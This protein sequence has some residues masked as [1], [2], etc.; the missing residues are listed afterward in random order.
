MDF[1][2]NFFILKI[3]FMKILYAF[4]IYSLYRNFATPK[5]ELTAANNALPPTQN[6]IKLVSN[7]NSAIPASE[8]TCNAVNSIAE[9]STKNL[10][11]EDFLFLNTIL[12][13]ISTYSPYIIT[14]TL[15]LTAGSWYCNYLFTNDEF[16]SKL[17]SLFIIYGL[18]PGIKQNSL[19]FYNIPTLE[20]PSMPEINTEASLNVLIS[21]PSI[22]AEPLILIHPCDI[23]ISNTSAVL[24]TV[25]DAV[26]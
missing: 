12:D 7:I 8:N 9:L 1:Y 10:V 2:K 20:T 23:N 19:S 3:S 14:I 18:H 16:L 4:L 24:E 5:I 13:N 26:S 17:A 22:T 21:T 11:T 6:Q 25:V 15:L